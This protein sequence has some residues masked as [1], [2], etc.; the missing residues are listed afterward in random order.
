MAPA[1][2]MNA[3]R[4]SVEFSQKGIKYGTNI[5]SLHFWFH[6]DSFLFVFLFIEIPILYLGARSKKILGPWESCAFTWTDVIR[7]RELQWKSG[8][9]SHSDDL[10]RNAFEDYRPS[11]SGSTPYYW[12]V[13]SEYS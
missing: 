3:T 9:A 10:I 1:I 4:K 7:D 13:V 11:K 12:V 8:D 2:I 5:F 6:L